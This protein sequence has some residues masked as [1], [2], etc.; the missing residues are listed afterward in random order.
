MTTKFI[1]EFEI[2][3]PY[4]VK[5]TIY[6][7]DGEFLEMVV[8]KTVSEAMRGLADEVEVWAVNEAMQQL[9]R[10]HERRGS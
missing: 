10:D 2:E 6:R 4:R 5:A 9:A 8:R 3:R 7:P 1:A